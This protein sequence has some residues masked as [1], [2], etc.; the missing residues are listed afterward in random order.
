MNS[1]QTTTQTPALPY[2]IGINVTVYRDDSK[3]SEYRAW[4][5]RSPSVLN[6]LFV[7]RITLSHFVESAEPTYTAAQWADKAERLV[8]EFPDCV[9]IYS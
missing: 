4:F 6:E 2:P 1:T 8:A 3:W 5:L 9:F 7:A